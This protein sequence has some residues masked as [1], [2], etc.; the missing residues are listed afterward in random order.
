MVIFIELIVFIL[1][2]VLIYIILS[3]IFGKNKNFIKATKVK[4]LFKKIDNKYGAF[5]KNLRRVAI[6]N[7]RIEK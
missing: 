2:I 5:L 3:S 7:Y 1:L 4:I 6:D